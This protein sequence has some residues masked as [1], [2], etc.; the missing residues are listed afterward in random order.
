VNA[1][2]PGSLGSSSGPPRNHS[3]NLSSLF[4]AQL[5]RAT[6]EPSFP[7]RSIQPSLGAFPKHGT[8]KLCEPADH[9]HHHTPCRCRRIDCFG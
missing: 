3:D 1:E 6:S 2:Q 4:I 8:F 7:A 9:L 5:W